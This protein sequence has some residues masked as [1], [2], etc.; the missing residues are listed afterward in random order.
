MDRDVLLPRKRLAWKV[1][2]GL[3]WSW[4]FLGFSV[5]Q[6]LAATVDCPLVVLDRLSSATAIHRST[7]F[8]GRVR[9]RFELVRA[10]IR[11][12]PRPIGF[13]CRIRLVS[14]GNVIQT[15]LTSRMRVPVRKDLGL[16]TN[17]C[18]YPR[19][20]ERFPPGNRRRPEDV[21][22]SAS[23]WGPSGRCGGCARPGDVWLCPRRSAEIVFWSLYGFSSWRT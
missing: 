7:C 17:C 19:R 9:W 5:R 10:S 21:A 20:R 14:L 15:D 3:E 11:R 12:S 2:C 22:I 4:A 18:I 1:R 13:D 6:T 23:V 8:R 16:S